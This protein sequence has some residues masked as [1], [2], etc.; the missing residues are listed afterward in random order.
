MK[1]LIKFVF[2]S[3]IGFIID[4]IIYTLLT[5]LFKVNIDIS[6]MISSICGVTFVFFMSTR[7]VFINN[8]TRLDIK[9]KYIIYIV[10]QL[11]LIFIVSKIMIILKNLFISIDIDLI[12]KYLSIIVKIAIT[13]FT[14]TIN[15]FVMKYL[16]KI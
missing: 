8:N 15:Y 1:K 2:I 4:F 10:Y 5:L 7:K 3:G 13:P 12:I 9:Y 16:T 6:N 11:L 14:L